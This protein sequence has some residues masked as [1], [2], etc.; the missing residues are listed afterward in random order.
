MQ[1]YTA[2]LRD[3]K[4][5][6]HEL[7]DYKGIAA[8]PGQE[9]F[10]ED[11]VDTVLEEAGKLAAEVLLPLNAV[12]EA[13]GCTLENGK[14]TTPTGF[15][16]AYN[17][18]REGGWTGLGA[19]QEYGGQ[20]FPEMIGK[21]V[22]EMICSAN[23]AFSL[24]P[25]LT[26][27]AR[28]AIAEHATAELKD[29]YL[30]KMIDGS[31]SGAM[32]LTEAHCGTDLGLLRTRAT[33]QEDGSYRINGS[34]IFISC[35][36]HD[37]VDN[38]VHLVLARLPDA[39]K[40]VKG[41]SLFLVPK[42]LPNEAGEPGQ[43]NGVTCS[44]L[45]HKM[46]LRGC[47][48]CQ[49]AFDDATGW[50]VG[51]PNKGMA[52]MFTMMNEE[53]LGVGIQG[54]GIGEI[55]YQSSVFYAK[56]RIQGR[57]LSGVKSP[58]KAADSIIVHP[59]VRRML[60]TQRAYNEGCRALGAWVARAVDVSRHSPSP[61]EREEAEEFIAFMTP[62]VKAM[63][64]DFGFDAA[65]L[66]V[67]VYGGHGFIKE[68]G[69]EQF[70]RD[71]RITMLY[72]GTNG[73][74]AL[75]LVGRKLPAHMGR[76]MRG[77]FHPIAEFIAENKSNPALATFLPGLEQAFGALQLTT[78]KLAEKMM[79]DPEEAGAASTDYLRLAGL[80]GIAYMFARSVLIAAPKVGEA[81]PEGEFY[82]AKIA[83]AQFFYDRILPQ[84]AAMFLQIK[85]GKKSMMALPEAAF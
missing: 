40:G 15:R 5:V 50:M 2:P 27:G 16:D 83:T 21:M 56:D 46:G 10:S 4:F 9:E 68:H 17:T 58:D 3:M 42:F 79:R 22:E 29:A 28:R 77:L 63:F 14:V 70:V 54:L 75:D 64:T 62:I 31:W 73:V 69:V 59:D 6:L 55:A 26:H 33:P 1:V 61:E 60:M 20:G 41:I 53:R 48:T 12:G 57:S 25:G 47:A 74:Q 30:P 71:A 52:A 37:M 85:A 80:V 49:M 18:F 23:L 82:K 65:S 35:G 8:L 34:K 45:E 81:G 78:G 36:D 38:V 72:E 44:G 43:R 84:T 39:P 24:Y 13:E 67:Q 32:C 51:Q 11:L 76:Y 19:P 66:A 7:H